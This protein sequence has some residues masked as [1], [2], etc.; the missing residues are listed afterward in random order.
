MQLCSSQILVQHASPS[1]LAWHWNDSAPPTTEIV[2]T[3][4]THGFAVVR[5][6]L[7]IELVC[8]LRREFFAAFSTSGVSADGEL[9]TAEQASAVVAQFG[10]PTH[11]SAHLQAT[12]HYRQLTQ[13]PALVGLAE[14]LLSDRVRLLPRQVLRLYTRFSRSGAMAHFD[15]AFIIRPPHMICNAWIPL[16][17]ADT[18]TGTLLYLPKSHLHDV[19]RSRDTYHSTLPMPPKDGYPFGPNLDEIAASMGLGP[20]E[21]IELGP[22]DISIHH[23]RTL[24]ASTDS[25]SNYARLTTDVRFAPSTWFSDPRWD[26]AWK[27]DDMHKWNLSNRPTAGEA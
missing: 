2:G 1:K 5:R 24:H 27:S 13:A 20:W 18:R 7:P 6:I 16:G 11:Q 21:Y 9:A 14:Q 19:Y 26:E 8:D 10:R 12:E 15:E 3:I 4:R 23:P 17:R 25:S 22:G